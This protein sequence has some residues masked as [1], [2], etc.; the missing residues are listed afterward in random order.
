MG[1]GGGVGLNGGMDL[2]HVSDLREVLT[3]RDRLSTS[4]GRF[5][6]IVRIKNCNFVLWK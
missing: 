6:A 1:G 4:A 5:N 3:L 2:I